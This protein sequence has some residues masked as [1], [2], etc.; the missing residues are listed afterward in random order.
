[1]QTTIKILDDLAKVGSSVLGLAMGV[2]DEM[3]NQVKACAQS[4]VRD[5]DLVS[6][7]EFEVVRS[8]AQKA[9]EENEKLK[10]RLDKLEKKPAK[11]PAKK[12]QKKK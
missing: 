8:M 11:K 5:M 2:K 4:W 3:K 9:R 1:M 10:A 7:D 6:R 12:A